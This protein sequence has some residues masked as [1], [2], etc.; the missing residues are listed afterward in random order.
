[1]AIAFV[2]NEVYAMHPF[3]FFLLLL[4]VAAAMYVAAAVVAL[5]RLRG[6]RV[7]ICPRTN[8]PAAVAV[9]PLE[10]VRT[11][12]GGQGNIA[13][14]DCSRWPDHAACDEACSAQVAIA[15]FATRVFA[16]AERFYTGKA[17]ALCL[18]AIAPL[19]SVG[20]QPGLLDRSRKQP[21][22]TIAWTDAPAEALP[23]LFA[24]HLPVCA[25]CHRREQFGEPAGGRGKGLRVA[26]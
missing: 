22:S 10:I 5:W 18:R 3:A 8:Q 17:C 14:R 24:T 21:P 11:A 12:I 19:R 16:V 9:T 20:A 4:G 6:Q 7:V 23:S 25:S 1:M 15:P 2:F 26:V 13:I